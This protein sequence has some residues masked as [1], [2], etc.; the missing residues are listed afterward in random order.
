METWHAGR[1]NLPTKQ[2]TDLKK[3]FYFLTY[4]LIVCTF[5]MWIHVS[6]LFVFLAQVTLPMANVCLCIF[7]SK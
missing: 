4:F 1:C 5:M 2:L 3:T 7:K 6:F